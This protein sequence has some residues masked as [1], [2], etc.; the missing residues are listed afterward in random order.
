MVQDIT[1]VTKI[2]GDDAARTKWFEDEKAKIDIAIQQLEV[3]EKE[4]ALKIEKMKQL[5]VLK[6]QKDELKM[7]RAEHEQK[8]KIEA[9]K[10]DQDHELKKMS[11]EQEAEIEKAKQGVGFTEEQLLA[12]QAGDR[13]ADVLISR[14][15]SQ[16]PIED[17]SGKMDKDIVDT[18]MKQQESFR[19]EQANL[20]NKTLDT[21]AGVASN[22]PVSIQTTTEGTTSSASETST[23]SSNTPSS[24]QD[25]LCTKCGLPN[26]LSSKFCENCGNKFI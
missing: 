13:A 16:R 10:L 18:M 12:R 5:M 24:S 3:D 20:L 23:L 11:I 1:L 14:S 25:R 9:I 6:A 2:K 26:P 17:I 8:L 22:R 15:E 21:V 19:Q 7:K 4:G